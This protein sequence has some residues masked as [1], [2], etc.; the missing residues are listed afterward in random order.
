MAINEQLTAATAATSTTTSE[1]SP[2]SPARDISTSSTSTTT[3]LTSSNNPGK[4]A[5][6]AQTFSATSSAKTTPSTDDA[7]T[8]SSTSETEQS[9]KSSVRPN[10]LSNFSSHNY[11]IQLQATDDSGLNEL[12]DTKKYNP[13]NWYTIINSSGGFKDP[14]LEDQDFFS[15]EYYIDNIEFETIPGINQRTRSTIECSLKFS[16]TE[17]YGLNF[18]KELWSFNTDVIGAENYFDTCYLLTIAWKGFEDS[19]KLVQLDQTKYIPF[20]ITNI[21][22]QV[23]PSGSVYNV[24]AIPYNYLG[25]TQLYGF[26][27]NGVTAT[28]DTLKELTDS[29]AENINKSVKKSAEEN[30]NQNED[31]VEPMVIYNFK[32]E[33]LNIPGVGIIDIGEL[34]LSSPD[35]INS[36]NKPLPAG[37]SAETHKELAS[38]MASFSTLG[39]AIPKGQSVPFTGKEQIAEALAQMIINSKYITDQIREFKKTYEEI[40]KKDPTPA[41]RIK[42]IKEELNKPVR[43]FKIVPE[44]ESVGNWNRFTNTRQKTITYKIVP[45]IIKDTRNANN[46]IG[47]QSLTPN[48]LSSA[49]VKEYFY[50]F[51]GKNSEI[52]NC[53]IKFNTM[54]FNFAQSNLSKI[55]M[56]SGTKPVRT[57]PSGS[58]TTIEKAKIADPLTSSSIATVPISP[59]RLGSSIGKF[60]PERSKAAEF[61]SILFSPI[62]LVNVDLEILGDP[63]LIMQD[64][65]IYSI[66]DMITEEKTD[67]YNGSIVMNSEERFFRLKFVSP[68]DIDLQTGLIKNKNESTVFDGIYRLML[69]RSHFKQGKFTQNLQLVKVAM[70]DPV[71]PEEERT[72]QQI[73]ADE[74]FDFINKQGDPDYIAQGK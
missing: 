47:P 56:A 35:E 50:F 9:E 70:I 55:N 63:D 10:A 48:D 16:I 66:T 5:S 71:I 23:Q 18:L 73:Y 34:P 1:A 65:I 37:L 60:T 14:K 36:I 52:L 67:G 29:L 13:S 24:E 74:Q 64:T 21:D 19:G 33:P 59:T 44:V 40:L 51:T 25:N 43:W 4:D 62:D 41:G 68:S 27:P 72:E 22:L 3:P 38:Q 32:F 39:T 17:P 57:A 28:G 69:V 11:I 42:L 53:D 26:I 15:S 49:I 58:A 7:T 6:N 12:L 61:S 54:Y 46:Y 8:T 45:Y 30:Y 31:T 20:R 2:Q